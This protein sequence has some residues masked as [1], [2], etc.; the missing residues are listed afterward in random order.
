MRGKCLKAFLRPLKAEG[1]PSHGGSNDHPGEK[2][3]MVGANGSGKSTILKLIIGQ[4]EPGAVT[5]VTVQNF[6]GSTAQNEVV[7]G[8]E[9][10]EEKLLNANR[11][12]MQD[13][14]TAT[15]G[16]PASGKLDFNNASSGA[17]APACATRWPA[18]PH[19]KARKPPHNPELN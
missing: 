4:I 3:G 1:N 14:L 8:T 2:V 11:Q 16:Q 13:V 18:C 17:L 9:L 19:S 6:T 15:F 5:V 7:I 10:Q 12:T